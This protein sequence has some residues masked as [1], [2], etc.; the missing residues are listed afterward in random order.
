MTHLTREEFAKVVMLAFCEGEDQYILKA[1][2]A[3]LARVE[4]LETRNRIAC[5]ALGDANE[6]H[7]TQLHTVTAERDAAKEAA[8]VVIEAGGPQPGFIS[9]WQGYC[10]K[11]M[12]I[13]DLQDRLAN[14]E[15]QVA[16]LKDPHSPGGQ[17]VVES[18][19]LA[20][21]RGEAKEGDCLEILR[22]L[23]ADATRLRDS[24]VEMMG[25]YER[26]IRSACL[27]QQQLDEKPW[28]VGEF[29]RAEIAL[30][31]PQYRNC[32]TCD[33]PARHLHPAMQHGGEVQPCRDPWH[34]P[35]TQAL[36]GKEA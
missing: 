26:R 11:K 28:R 2:D 8:R 19:L 13:E 22:R 20:A 32:P 7:R 15:R 12:E 14:L 30:A 16:D 25:L 4:E 21:Q 17:S 33:S 31:G 3:L 6:R 35:A 29:V 34:T 23:Q 24:L 5:N 18:W 27:S 36:A 9:L 10:D 1:Y